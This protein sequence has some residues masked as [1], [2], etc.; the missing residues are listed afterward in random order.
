MVGVPRAGRVLRAFPGR[1]DRRVGFRVA[2]ER[3]VPR[4]RCRPI[5]RARGAR[6][7]VLLRD[8]GTRLRV[9]I[10]AVRSGRVTTVRSRATRPVLRPVP[11]TRGPRAAGPAVRPRR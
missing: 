3:C 8:V 5:P 11:G 10:T 4:G 7:R 6:H 9:R 2:W 1:W